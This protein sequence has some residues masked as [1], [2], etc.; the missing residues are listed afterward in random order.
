MI[1][2]EGEVVRIESLEGD[3]F[4]E[5]YPTLTGVVLLVSDGTSETATV[6]ADESRD[7]VA[8]K[9][10]TIDPLISNLTSGD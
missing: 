2:P 10:F 7:L 4:V 3:G 1:E 5:I 8:T 9:L 6:L